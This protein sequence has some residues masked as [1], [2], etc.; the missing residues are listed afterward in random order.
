MNHKRP[1]GLSNQ[2]GYWTTRGRVVE[3]GSHPG[4]VRGNALP[5]RADAQ[6][7]GGGS[8][9]KAGRRSLVGHIQILQLL[10]G[11]TVYLLAVAGVWWTANRLS[12]DYFHQQAT[13][14]LIKLDEL[15]TPLYVSG[16]D[17]EFSS[18]RKQISELPEL[19][20]VR[21]YNATGDRILAEYNARP[22][23]QSNLPHL[24]REQ[25][26]TLRDIKSPTHPYFLETPAFRPALVRASAPVWVRSIESDGL[27]EFN[28]EEQQDEM[29]ELI[30][31]VEV[32][33]DFS[34]YQGQ[35]LKNI[36]LGSLIIALLLAASVFGG[37]HVL[38]RALRPLQDLQKPLARLANGDIDVSVE[39]T[40]HKE[41]MAISN[42]LNATISA[43]RQRDESL[44]HL[45]DHDQLTGLVNRHCF[46]RKVEEEV[47]RVGREGGSSALLFVD[48]D[49]FKLVNDTL[50][51]AAGDRLLIQV[52]NKLKSCLQDDDIV[53][54]FGGDEFTLLA[55]RV[56]ATRAADLAAAIVKFMREFHFV[57][58]RQVLNI[59]CSIGV[60]MI[61]SACFAPDE[62]LAQADMAC[63]DAKSRGR[64]CYSLFTRGTY[65]PAQ[66]MAYMGWSQKIKQA[67]A[68][69]GFV[70]HYQ[71]IIS[72]A[73]GQTELFEVLL[74][75]PDNGESLSPT[76]FLPVAERFGLMLEV[77][78]WVIQNALRSLAKFRAR[79]KTTKFCINLSGHIFE[80]PRLVDTVCASLEH[81]DLPPSSVVFEV[82]E[83][84]A[85]RY[86]ANANRN[87]RALMDVGCRFA[88]DDFGSGFSSLTYMKRLPVDFIKI[89]GSFIKNVSR[90][91]IDQA[92]VKSIVQIAQT[93]GKKTIAEYVQ[94]AKS[95][96]ILR[97]LGAD[98]AQGFYI[99]EPAQ[100]PL[101]PKPSKLKRLRSG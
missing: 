68:N 28:L 99:G 61:D 79:R 50:G 63:Y 48:L 37:R 3:T 59:G 90:D 12:E 89:E 74:R 15:G 52:A 6:V 17:T 53:C 21:Y 80:D 71:P 91:S 1:L 47:A 34:Q 19:A 70:L 45:V 77:D 24:S 81:N 94:D 96:D 41:I 100:T 65:D 66:M 76:V 92:M 83:Q 67:L 69:N 75:L 22:L 8:R 27:L 82:T 78:L 13:Q 97:Q 44:R 64:G 9:G 26:D 16:G 58:A 5:I 46:A 32:G 11:I 2:K 98:Y 93:T 38:K 35:L 55:R 40:G 10:L 88:L 42:A 25:L 39:N 84:V 30:G 54:R 31:F 18:I 56:D 29:L 20:F 36:A 95:L 4:S 57:E 62:L 87:M 33:L 60:A 49:Q 101:L 85:I 73:N 86:F 14:W 51:H 72:L 7:G 43:L 23:Q